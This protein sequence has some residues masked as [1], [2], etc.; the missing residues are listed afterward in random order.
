MFVGLNDISHN[1]CQEVI[2]RKKCERFHFTKV[3]EH[4]G[5]SSLPQ[6]IVLLEKHFI[7]LC[8]EGRPRPAQ[9]SFSTKFVPNHVHS[10]PAICRIELY[11]CSY[12]FMHLEVKTIMIVL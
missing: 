12:R 9:I 7:F 10:L 3:L 1:G 8:E 11:F 2:V 4:I 6:N 5:V